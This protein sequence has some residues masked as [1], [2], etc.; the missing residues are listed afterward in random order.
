MF[1]H[2]TDETEVGK[3]RKQMKNKKSSGHDGITNEILKCCSPIIETYLAKTFN[4]C[5]EGGTFPSSFKIAKVIYPS[6]QKRQ[7]QRSGELSTT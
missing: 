2:P 7:S 4:N 1:L 3:T 6:I 5:F